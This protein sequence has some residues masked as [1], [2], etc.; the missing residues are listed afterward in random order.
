MVI[1][2][3]VSRACSFESIL[4]IPNYP[5]KQKQLLYNKRNFSLIRPCFQ[6]FSD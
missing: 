4:S 1:T 6:L 5:A 3:Q 2:E